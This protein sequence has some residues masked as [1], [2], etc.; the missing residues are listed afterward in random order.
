[1]TEK[2]EKE[3]TISEIPYH[4]I[5]ADRLKVLKP[6]IGDMHTH[7]EHIEDLEYD[8]V[9]KYLLT[10]PLR[11]LRMIRRIYNL[12]VWDEWNKMEYVFE[13]SIEKGGR[14]VLSYEDCALGEIK[15]H[16]KS[17]PQEDPEPEYDNTT[18]E[19]AFVVPRQFNEITSSSFMYPEGNML[20][21]RKHFLEHFWR[22]NNP[23]KF[24]DGMKLNGFEI[25]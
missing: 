11:T 4:H 3:L 10:L 25:D 5:P 8:E 24:E 15:T 13:H 7:I 16:L 1:M 12:A 14:V 23:Y 19:F 6:H 9:E 17:S 18:Y 20:S 22:E 21:D 2:E